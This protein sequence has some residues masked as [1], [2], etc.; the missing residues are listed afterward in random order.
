MQMQLS[1][2]MIAVINSLLVQG[3][4]Y[5]VE[6]HVWRAYLVFKPQYVEMS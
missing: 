1:K 4:M 3:N 6:V 5:L 2:E